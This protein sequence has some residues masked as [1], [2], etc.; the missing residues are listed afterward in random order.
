MFFLSWKRNNGD[1][2]TRP[3]MHKALWLYIHEMNL[4]VLLSEYS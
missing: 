1:Y 4:Y 2:L 3:S